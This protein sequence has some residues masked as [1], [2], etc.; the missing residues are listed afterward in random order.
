MIVGAHVVVLIVVL[1]VIKKLLLGDTIRAVERVGQA[2]A[3]IRKKEEA[4]RQE[5]E[6]HEQELG[7]R[8]KEVERDQDVRREEGERQIAQLKERTLEE[9]RRESADILD[10]AR[11]NDRKLREQLQ[12]EM[13]EKAVDF[14]GR[15]FKLV[16]S[17]RISAE[18]NKHFINELI[19]ALQETDATGIT[20]D[21][22]SAE[23]ISSHPLIPEQKER[24]QNLL[25]SKFGVR[26]E[27]RETVRE[28]L[29]AGLVMK[30]GSL[31]IDGSLLSRYQEAVTELKKEAV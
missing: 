7:A 2:E 26:I 11:K 4:M 16:F 18:L 19:E 14:G 24:L 3:E 27:I 31:E 23:F 22:A 12:L 30:L 17:E 1:S 5:L 6:R 15:V 21:A 13:Q 9:A 8:R 29:L 10:K 28:D 20:V 25:A